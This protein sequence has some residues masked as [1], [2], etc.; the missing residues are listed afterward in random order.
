MD[1]KAK[2]EVDFIA[3]ILL[4]T[5][6]IKLTISYCNSYGKYLI[7]PREGIILSLLDIVVHVVAVII[8]AL[9]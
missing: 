1:T 9:M 6:I 8:E 2:T 3:V 4:I 5:S 7:H